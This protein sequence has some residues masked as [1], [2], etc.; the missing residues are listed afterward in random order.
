M[1]AKAFSVWTGRNDHSAEVIKSL[2]ANNG[3]VWCRTVLV[4]PLQPCR[5]NII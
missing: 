2:V 4:E 1:N 5:H 3:V